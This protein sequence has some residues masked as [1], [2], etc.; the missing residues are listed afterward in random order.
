MEENPYPSLEEIGS[1]LSDTR[2]LE[3]I[4]FSNF[5]D[6]VPFYKKGCFRLPT[7]V[8][9]EDDILNGQI[10]KKDEFAKNLVTGNLSSG[11]SALLLLDTLKGIEV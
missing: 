9:L 6:L 10:F 8:N 1:I 7:F 4:G 2:L 5:D 11:G 3:K